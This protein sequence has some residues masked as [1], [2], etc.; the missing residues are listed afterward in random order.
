MILGGTV[1]EPPVTVIPK[2]DP[3]L[4]FPMV[5]AN[6]MSFLLVP[7]QTIHTL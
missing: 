3:Y 1:Q 6:E 2:D 5:L 7:G 4:K